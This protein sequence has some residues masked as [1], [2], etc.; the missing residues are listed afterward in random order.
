MPKFRITGLVPLDGYDWYLLNHDGHDDGCFIRQGGHC[1]CGWEDTLENLPADA[2]EF[3]RGYDHIIEAPNLKQALQD[4]GID[5]EAWQRL[6]ATPI[7]EP[8]MFQALKDLHHWAL[9]YL[10][11]IRYHAGTPHSNKERVQE[12]LSK[13]LDEAKTIISRRD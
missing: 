3:W 4:T 12:L 8:D 2:P 9:R 11:E 6:S 1:D 13:A 7:D 5:L 10:G